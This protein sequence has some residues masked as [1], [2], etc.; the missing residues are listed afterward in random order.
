[1]TNLEMDMLLSCLSFFSSWNYETEKARS[2]VE[3]LI[4]LHLIHPEYFFIGAEL[5]TLLVGTFQEV[6]QGMSAADLE[7]SRHRISAFLSTH[8]AYELLPESGK[9]WMLYL[10]QELTECS[11]AMFS[12]TTEMLKSC[13]LCLPFQVIAL[14]VT[15][16]VKRAFHILYEQV[17]LY[18]ACKHGQT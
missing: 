13:L 2:L 7:V 12:T 3:I 1:M 5:V 16:P 18:Y 17:N 6:I 11:F 8:T 10:L 9:V 15:L 14:D 4:I